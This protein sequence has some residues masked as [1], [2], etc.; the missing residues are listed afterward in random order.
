MYKYDTGARSPVSFIISCPP[1]LFQGSPGERG[2]VGPSGGIGLP[3][4]SGGQG[5]IGPA[6]EKGSPVSVCWLTFSGET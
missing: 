1:P 5:P 4:Q 6:G 3:G 2:P